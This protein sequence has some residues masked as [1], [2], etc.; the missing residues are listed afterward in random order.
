MV[1]ALVM[2]INRSP[3]HDLLAQL[4][5]DVRLTGDPQ[6]D[7]LTFFTF[8]DYT[9]T[10]EHCQR[11]AAEAARLAEQFDVDPCQARVAGWLHDVSAVIP[12]SQRVL[13]AGQ[14]SLEVLPEEERAPMLL[15]QK[16][17][18]V[19]AEQIFGIEDLSVLSAVRC[20]TTLRAHAGL[21]DKVV[22][23][24]DK[25]AWDQTG[26]PPYLGEIT[27]AL[28]RS[29]DDATLCYLRYLWQQRETLAAVHPWFVDAYL[30]QRR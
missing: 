29:L 14:L 9:K 27:Q 20:H 6:A 4:V 23:C 18:A 3:L 30:E 8:H 11:V 16:L 12:V 15:H 25:I 7:V 28:H 2:R 13:Y 17:S 22:F 19:M 24:A 1:H 21:L 5:R 26:A 10:M